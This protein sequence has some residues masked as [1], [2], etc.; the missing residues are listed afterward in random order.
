MGVAPYVVLMQ[1]NWKAAQKSGMDAVSAYVVQR[2]PT[3]AAGAPY[4]ESIAVP[5]AQTW[6]RQEGGEPRSV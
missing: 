5:E 3:R 6:A 2:N 4:N 1:P